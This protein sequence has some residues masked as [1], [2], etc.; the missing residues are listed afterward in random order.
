MPD[1]VDSWEYIELANEARFNDGFDP[2]KYPDE[3]ELY[4]SGADP[5]LYPNTNW[6]DELLDRTVNNQRYTL[7]FRGGA[8]SYICNDH[9]RH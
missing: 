4:R 2:Y 7:N 9:G 3:I 1:F 8:K 5:D 6:M